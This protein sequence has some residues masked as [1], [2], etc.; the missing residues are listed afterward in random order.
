VEVAGTV[1][2]DRDGT[3]IRDVG[4]LSSIKDVEILNGVMSGL[5]M[6]LSKNY[7]LHI[8]SNQSGV[9]RGLVTTAEFQTVEKYFVDLFHKNGVQF[10]SL[11]Y[12]FHLPSAGCSCRKPQTGLFEA[13]SVN[14]QI[15]KKRTAMVGNSLVDLEAAE[16]FGIAYWG[17]DQDNSDF[18][19]V[20][21]EV[22]GYFE[23]S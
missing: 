18:L 7:R 20:A 11:N 16:K 3:L 17:I 5:K 9:P 6:F 19:Q 8:V 10:D 4:Y 22:I 23:T 14:F 15:D 13:V 12:C 1:F 2:L 21:Q